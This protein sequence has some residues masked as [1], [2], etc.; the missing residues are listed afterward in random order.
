M[1]LARRGITSKCRWL[2]QSAGTEYHIFDPLASGIS[3]PQTDLERQLAEAELERHFQE[4]QQS[5]HRRRSDEL[6]QV[7]IHPLP[8]EVTPLITETRRLSKKHL[9]KMN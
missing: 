9:E 2:P 5:S 6:E 1:S 8:D 7:A 4:E 3:Y